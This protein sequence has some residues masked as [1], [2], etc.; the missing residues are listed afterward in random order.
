MKTINPDNF[1]LKTDSYKVPHF[2]QY[3]ANTT[4]VHSFFESRGG[5]Y[6]AVLFFG[7][8]SMIKEHLLGQVVTE[9]SIEE[10]K[11]LFALH[12]GSTALFNEPGWRYILEKHDG[13]LPIEIKAVLEGT[14]VPVSNVLMTV[15]N[16]DPNVPWI[17]NYVETLLVQLWYPI[18]V[19]TQSYYMKQVILRYLEE[20]G[21]PEDVDFKLHDFGYRGSTSVDSAGIGGAAHLVN[22][23][24]TDTLKALLIARNHYGEEMAGF[25]IP[26]AEHSTIT[27]WGKDHEVDAYENMLNLYPTGF[28][29]VVSDSY[30]IYEACEKIWG[31]ILKNKVLARDGTLVIRPDSGDPIEV[32]PRVLEILGEKFGY[33]TNGKGYKVLNPKVRL[34]QGD[35]IDHESVGVILE[36]LKIAGWS[37]DN[38]AFGSGGGLLQKLNRDTQ[39]FAFKCSA[40]L[41]NGLWQDVIKDPVT[42][43][44]KRSKAGVLALVHNGEGYQTIREEDLNGQWNELRTVFRNGELLVNQ[45]FAAIRKQAQG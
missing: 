42:D 36:A 38:L 22:F 34:I 21:T 3:P 30:N 15:T 43:P 32:L 11:E 5:R 45:P 16:T 1:L 14:K 25:S 44:G 27:S 18:T 29:A 20:T 33:T 8:Q 2:Q 9:E 13:R 4:Y 23:K 31:G 35:G 37:A 12:F 10:A 26:A 24:G 6:P 40:A 39:K 17:T 41:V 7:L 28:V 19:A